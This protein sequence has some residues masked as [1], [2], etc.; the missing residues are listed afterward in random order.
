M[1]KGQ[2]LDRLLRLSGIRRGPPVRCPFL[3]AVPAE[4]SRPHEIQNLNIRTGE[5]V[6]DA[7][8]AGNVQSVDR[9]LVGNCLDLGKIFYYWPIA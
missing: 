3:H 6:D 4:E 9:T 8:A 7:Q 1:G 5:L 2:A